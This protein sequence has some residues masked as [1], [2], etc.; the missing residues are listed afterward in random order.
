MSTRV[1]DRVDDWD[2]RSFNGGYAELHDLASRDF[3]GVIRA[4]GA[5]LYMTKGNVVGIRRGDIE[6]FEDQTGTVY[7]SPSPALPLLAVMQERNEEVRDKF[8]TEK[9]PISEVDKT[10]TDGGFTGFI[11]LSENVLSGD[12]YLVYHAGTSMSVGFVGNSSRLMDG[13]EAFETADDEVGIYQVRPAEITVIDIPSPPDDEPVAEPGATDA[14]DAQDTADEEAGADEAPAAEGEHTAEPAPG[15]TGT[16]AGGHEGAEQAGGDAANAPAQAA[17]QPGSQES[18]RQPG[19]QQAQR[20]Q[21]QQGQQPAQQTGQREAGA[22]R[23]QQTGTQSQQPTQNTGQQSANTQ[24]R[25]QAQGQASQ[26]RQRTPTAESSV[27]LERRAIPSLDPTQ[28]KAPETESNSPQSGPKPAGQPPQQQP[29][30]TEQP[31]PAPQQPPAEPAQESPDPE[32]AIDPSELEELE[33]EI[34][35]KDDQIE[36]LEAE[37]ESTESEREELEDELEALRSERDELAETVEDLEGELERLETEL[38]AATDAE[39]RMTP[40]EALRGTDIFIRFASKGDATLEKAHGGSMRK[41]DVNDNMRLEKHTQFDKQAV[42]IGGQSYDEFLESTLEYQFVE[43]VVRDLLFEIRETGH[44]KAL[45][46]LYDILP[47]VDRAELAGVV[48]VTY[49]EDGQETRTQE[50]FDVVLRN[51]MGN[52][53]L[54]ATLNDSREGA[55]ESMMENLI[56]SAERVGQ[57]VDEFSGAFLVTRSFFEPGALEVASQSTQGGILSRDKRKSYVNLSRKRGYHLC[58]VEA[59]NENFHLAVPEL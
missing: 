7:A 4:G 51:R 39:Q 17:E 40:G 21:P 49:T 20:T 18:E 2:E 46:D 45:K 29:T 48:E 50:S 25:Q 6:D 23:G 15:V 3:S 47:Q 27:D 33:A 41:E 14:G 34:D 54:V 9:T 31:D 28:T 16:G 13:D 57:A 11:E 37:L 38:G 1:V 12:Y 22:G 52:P 44:Q 32:P 42:A 26:Q 53:L 8:Y 24:A 36:E 55:T 43:W 35:E 56:T 59:R 10:L 30:Q 5:E 19:E 58:L